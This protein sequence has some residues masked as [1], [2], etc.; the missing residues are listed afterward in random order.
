MP[1]IRKARTLAK[2]TFASRKIDRLQNAAIMQN[3]KEIKNLKKPVEKKFLDT[4]IYNSIT[5]TTLSTVLNNVT[6]AAADGTVA[7]NNAA[8]SQRKGKD[9]TMQ[10]IQI[11]GVI[12]NDAANA[13]PDNNC[14]VRMIVCRFPDGLVNS[15]T[16]ISACLREVQGSLDP[17]IYSLKEPYPKQPYDILLDRT[18][19]LQSP[20]QNVEQQYPVEPWRVKVNAFIKLKGKAQNARWADTESV[21]SP[22]NNG[23]TVFLISNS[24][25]VSHPEA[26]L[27][28]RLKYLDM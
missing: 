20:Y 21:S 13:S 4:T 3:K 27:V 5:T 22:S 24:G 26:N 10:S 25:T 2:G 18:Y 7:T 28:C 1:K 9:I 17:F 8:M 19:H 23:I 11:K 16:P 6:P 12:F 14:A 15:G